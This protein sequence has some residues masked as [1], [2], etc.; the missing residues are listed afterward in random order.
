MR[1][2]KVSLL[3]MVLL[4]YF[5]SQTMSLQTPATAYKASVFNT[6]TVITPISIPFAETTTTVEV[7]TTT[8]EVTTTTQE[9][10]TTTGAPRVRV[11]ITTVAPVVTTRPVVVVSDG[12]GPPHNTTTLV[13]CISYWESSW[14]KDP[15]VFQFAQGTWEHYGGTGSPSNATYSKQLAIFWIAWEDDGPHHWAAQKGRC[16]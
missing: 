13:G 5:G 7:T 6:E 14:G 15:N 2:A 11:T 1:N 10:T 9:A 8:Q 4:A 3:A 16:F 12:D